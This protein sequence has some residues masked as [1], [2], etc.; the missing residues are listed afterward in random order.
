[1]TLLTVSDIS[2]TGLGN[3]KL[4]RITFSQ[5]KNQKI[6]L[7]GETGSGKSTLLKIIAGLE[8][9]DRG[10]VVFKTRI[11]K[12]PAEN[13]VPGHPGI[14][15]L[16]QDFELPKF[17]RVEQILSYANNLTEA[18]AKTLFDVC[19]ISHLLDRKSDELSGGERQRIALARLLIGSPELLLLDEPFSNLD[20]V[21]RNTLKNVLEKICK[22]LKITC[23][24]VSHEPADVLS[25]A[26][27]IIVMKSGEIV[28]DG[29]A[30][31]IY[32]MPV[33]EYVAGLFG[34]YNLL[35]G[36]NALSLIERWGMKATK[37]RLLIRPE[38]LKIV[39]KKHNAV[40]GKV[41][42]V[43][44]FGSYYEINVKVEELNILI[45]SKKNKAK[46]GDRVYV[47]CSSGDVNYLDS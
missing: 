6:A 21:H 30:K 10:D 24:L 7:A 11:V 28:Q 2:K 12:G 33:S 41:V 14:A 23:I 15:Y 16:S 3:F 47:K 35:D 5:R 4:Q 18:E 20:M 17:L 37:K 46:R 32:R 22:H 43:S 9:A 25:W 31:K 27:K 8:Q 42:A 1:M 45:R 29:S 13:L 40:P 19:E 26:D 38:N 34:N 36:A 39:T 44:Y